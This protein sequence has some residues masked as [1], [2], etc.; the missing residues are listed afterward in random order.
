MSKS[1][2]PDSVVA[3]LHGIIPSRV[4]FRSHSTVIVA[5]FHT[6]VAPFPVLQ[7]PMYNKCSIYLRQQ[8]ATDSLSNVRQF[9]QVRVPAASGTLVNSQIRRKNKRR[10]SK[11]ISLSLAVRA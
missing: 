10:A 4:L 11:L 6:D 8:S 1:R 5:L 2:F 7:H 3:L 9:L